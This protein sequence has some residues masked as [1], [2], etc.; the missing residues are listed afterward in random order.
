[1]MTIL[2]YCRTDILCVKGLTCNFGNERFHRVILEYSDKY[3]DVQPCKRKLIVNEVYNVILKD[4]NTWFLKPRNGTA[5]HGNFWEELNV[6][7]IRD[8]IVRH[9]PRRKNRNRPRH[10]GNAK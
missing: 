1:M 10:P 5:G 2:E 6:R 8:K 7:S 4:G 9:S 3:Q